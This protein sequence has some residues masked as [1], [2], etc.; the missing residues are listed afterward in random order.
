ME[1][2]V[3]RQTAFRLDSGLLDMLKAAAK[4]E[5]RRGRVKSNFDPVFYVI[6]RGNGG[7]R[8]SRVPFR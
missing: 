7:G 3:K 2:T 1:T 5:H 4:K 8:S 6:W